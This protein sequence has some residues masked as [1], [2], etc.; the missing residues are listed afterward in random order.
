M[1]M[2]RVA[3]ILATLGVASDACA[4]FAMIMAPANFSPLPVR[5]WKSLRDH[6]IVKQDL[7]YSC[8]SA[9]LATL[10]NGFYGESF[11]EQDF[12]KAMD[13]GNKKASF[14]DMARVLPRFGYK[15]QGFSSG[16]E[17]L[18][19]LQIPVVVY[20]KYRKEDHFS[21]IRGIDSSSVWLADPSFGNRIF[22]K[23]EFLEMWQI[24]GRETESQEATE[25]GRI[26]VILPIGERDR[27][28]Q[29][30]SRSPPRRTA[31]SER[32]VSLRN[33]P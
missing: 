14:E 7:D 31:V 30:F 16:W 2:V 19:Q 18:S 24:S 5:S 6:R 10:L 28:S 4:D 1:I 25:R 13:N 3:C 17:Q 12:L 27:D 9:S 33:W 23:E 22:S 11:K 26:L 29:F 8:G 32:I 20:L 15:A 21:V